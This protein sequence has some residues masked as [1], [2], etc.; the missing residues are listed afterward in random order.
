MGFR[1]PSLQD[2][3]DAIRVNVFEIQSPY[4]DGFLQSGCK[5]EL[6]KLKCYL[7][8]VYAQLPKFV[9]EEEWEQERVVEILKRKT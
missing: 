6:Y 3:Y 2:A 1:K 5:K 8:D 7:D 4:N 9:G